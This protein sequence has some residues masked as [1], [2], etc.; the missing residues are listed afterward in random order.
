MSVIPSP[1]YLRCEYTVN[2][3]GIDVLYP[4]FSWILGHSERGCRQ[5]AYQILVA[6][7]RENLLNDIG[8]IWDSKKVDSDKTVNVEYAGKP[9]ESTKT[10]YW[11]VRWWDNKEQ[12]SPFSE[13]AIFEVGLL[14]EN[15]WEAKWICGGNLL[16][17]RFK[18]GHKV[19]RGRA[20]ICGLGYYELRINGKKVGDHEL[21]PGWTD[22][23]KVV[24]YST[25]DI[26][27]LLREGENVVG[28]MLGR[29][30][31]SQDLAAFSPPIIQPL[32]KKYQ[33]AS[34]KII[35][36]LFL[37]FDDDTWVNIVTDETWKVLHGPVVADDLYLGE[38]YD[39][40][41]EKDRWD[42][43]DFEDDTWESAKKARPPG[44]QLVSQATLPPIKKIKTMQPITL[45]NP[46]AGVYVYDFGQNFTGWIRLTVSGPRGIQV[47]LRHAELLDSEGMINQAP[48]MA[49]KATDT[50]VLKGDGIEVYEPRFTYHGFR[51]LEVT[52]FPGTPSL[53][54]VQGIVVHSA[55]QP[56]G[57]FICS[58]RLINNIHKNVLW[59]QM[60]N[61]MSIPTDC[62]QRS[63]RMGWMGDAQLVVEESTY[64]FDMAGFYTKWMRDIKEAQEKDGSLPDV[65]PPYWRIYPADP[66]WGTACIVIPWQLFLFYDDIRILEENYEVMKGWVDFLGTVARRHLVRN[67]KYGDWC[68]PGADFSLS[69][70]TTKSPETPVELVATWYYYQDLV[71]LSRI[72][73]ALKKTTQAKEYARLAEQV[74]EAFN[75][76]FLK[77][78]SYGS[79]TANILPLYLGMVP[80]HKIEPI[81]EKLLQDIENEHGGHINTGIVGTRYI[82]DTL[83][84]YGRADLAYKLVNQTTYP[85][86]GYMIRKG[87]TTLWE[88]W[89]YMAGASMNSHNHIMFG[90]V[91]AWFY[92]ALAGINI[93]TSYPGFKRV[94]IKPHI[95]GNLSHVSASINTIRGLVSSSWRKEDNSL[96]VSVT[97]PVNT[98]GS[99]SIPLLGMKNPIIKEGEEIVFQDD[100]FISKVPGVTSGK[101]D[102]GY[103]TFGVGSG[104]YS[105]CAGESF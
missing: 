10:C 24:L 77:G 52:G 23:E 5:A 41:L 95:V 62:P 34:P 39:A 38:N 87:A 15:D 26:T 64:N 30:R 12:V 68:P 97:L 31:Y 37:Q 14:E 92:K 54:S 79:Q 103:I 59:S 11:K 91:D 102:N 19:K 72:A 78:S 4:R 45:S 56:V 35:A 105:F 101:R 42:S 49:A 6:S 40:R 51:Y 73:L 76:K 47:T 2:P 89:E 58:N 28:V 29:G 48:L 43:P 81:M 32:V 94:I 55:V 69:G 86:W 66:A 8:D 9:L 104:L 57:E 67:G 63:E 7:S 21:D 3:I 82:L 65:V 18:V 99:I 90:S 71:L 46:K 44:G 100:S 88:R 22:Y 20:Y 96:I 61:V 36:Q 60:S 53:D 75:K 13:I 93:N 17:R 25:Y 33:D 84:E 98:E 80:E 1:S 27:G 85:S 50:Y 83:T 70:V 16:R 74:K